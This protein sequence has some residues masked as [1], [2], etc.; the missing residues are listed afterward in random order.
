MIGKGSSVI[1]S[2]A[3]GGLVSST[4]VTATMSEQSKSDPQNSHLYVVGTLL[5]NCIMFIRVIFIVFFFNITLMGVFLLP[6]VMMLLALVIA[7]IYFY[8]RSKNEKPKKKIS[9]DEKVKSPFSIMP[10]VKF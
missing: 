7:T 3:I 9:L 6:A 10:A 2:S 5:A 1:L 4:A 8:I